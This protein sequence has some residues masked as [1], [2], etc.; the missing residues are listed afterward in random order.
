M[1]PF[2]RVGAELMVRGLPRDHRQSLVAIVPAVEP[3]GIVVF[4]FAA[5]VVLL[6]TAAPAAALLRAMLA[7]AA[8]A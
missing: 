4:A 8:A 2:Q 6:L 1:R 5:A 3:E 7:A